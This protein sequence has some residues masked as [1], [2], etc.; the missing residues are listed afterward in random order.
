MQFSDGDLIIKLG[1]KSEEW[2][3]IH[4]AVLREASPYFHAS[5]SDQWE[6]G[7]SKPEM[8]FNPALGKDVPMRCRV[9]R[10][11][12]DTYLLEREVSK[13]SLKR[14]DHD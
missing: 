4:S 8:I 5:F 10:F 6:Q 14:Q 12:E 11:V 1:L 13:P 7:D 9:L 3:V 2:L